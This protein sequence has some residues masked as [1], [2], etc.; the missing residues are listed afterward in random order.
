MRRELRPHL[1][2]LLPVLCRWFCAAAVG[3]PI[4]VIDLAPFYDPQRSFF[5]LPEEE[6]LACNSKPGF[7]RGYVGVGAESGTDLLEYKEVGYVLRLEASGLHTSCNGWVHLRAFSIG[8]PW[9]EGRAT[10]NSLQGPN[11]WPPE[12]ALGAPWRAR[13]L[14]TFATT[15][16][17]VEAAG[18]AASLALGGM[19]LASPL[20]RV[21]SGP[22]RLSYVLF[23]YP[24]FETRLRDVGAGSCQSRAQAYVGRQAKVASV[25]APKGV[26]YNTLLD[27]ASL[28]ELQDMPFGEYIEA[29][30]K[31]VTK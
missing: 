4:A 24:A 22:E 21:V 31:G 28:E 30:W 10:E 20:H 5:D 27:T 15:V 6:K 7:S 2:L 16:K 1:P 3:D 8:Y 14:S 26:E 23:Y 13:M 25:V 9:R 19:R 11:V 18:R 17:L 12:A 29:K